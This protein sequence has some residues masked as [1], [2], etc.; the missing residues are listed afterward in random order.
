MTGNV[1]GVVVT[2]EGDG[3]VRPVEILG[4]HHLSYK[5]LPMFPFALSRCDLRHRFIVDHV[6]VV[7]HRESIVI[8]ADAPVVTLV[9]LLVVLLDA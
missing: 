3:G 7:N 5:D 8:H 9:L 6:T 4:N 2:V 1:V